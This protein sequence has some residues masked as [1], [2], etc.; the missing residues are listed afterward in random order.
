M[1]TIL[2]REYLDSR[3]GGWVDY[4]PLRIAQ[5]G[6]KKCTNKTLC[7][8]NINILLPLKP[9]FYLQQFH[10]CAVVRNSRAHVNE[11]YAKY[12]GLK[13][14][15]HLVVRCATHN[16]VPILNGYD[17]EHYILLHILISYVLY[18]PQFQFSLISIHKSTTTLNCMLVFSND[19]YA[20]Q[21]RLTQKMIGNSFTNSIIKY[22]N[23]NNNL[24]NYNFDVNSSIKYCFITTLFFLTFLILYTKLHVKRHIN[25]TLLLRR[26]ISIY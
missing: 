19:F 17:D 14:D 20:I 21:D 3:V 12:V 18:I 23:I 11:K 10:T 2:T 1:T 6:T 26:N 8:E 7:K 4:A 13:R 25:R 24:C 16:M 15:F 5:L 22:I 9:L